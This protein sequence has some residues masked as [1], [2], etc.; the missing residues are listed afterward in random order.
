MDSLLVRCLLFEY[1]KNDSKLIIDLDD[2]PEKY[3]NYQDCKG[4]ELIKDLVLVCFE[5]FGKK[6]LDFLQCSDNFKI[7]IVSDKDLSQNWMHI[8]DTG[9]EIYILTI[10]K[11]TIL[12]YHLSMKQYICDECM[13][14][15]VLPLCKNNNYNLC[16]NM[17]DIEILDFNYFEQLF[18]VQAAFLF[19]N[20]FNNFNKL[21]VFVWENL[22]CRL[23]QGIKLVTYSLRRG[24]TIKPE[25]D[26]NILQ[27]NDQS[28]QSILEILRTL[29]L[30]TELLNI[31]YQY[32]NYIEYF[33]ND[34]KTL[35]LSL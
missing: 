17:I 23:I 31:V 15:S 29:P 18:P 11:N 14:N 20:Y 1:K 21:L 26:Y 4:N 22:P 33:N 9:H 27:E 6:C 16:K 25:W 34:M 19:Y 30:L 2:L 28:F 24:Y 3:K 8:V 13:N 10:V 5:K 35:I 7:L 32:I 12:V